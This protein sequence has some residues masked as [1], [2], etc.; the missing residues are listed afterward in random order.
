MIETIRELIEKGYKITR[1]DADIYTVMRRR[2]ENITSRRTRTNTQ[3]DE[4]DT[5]YCIMVELKNGDEI[6]KFEKIYDSQGMYGIDLRA[7]G[8]IYIGPRLVV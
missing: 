7:F 8:E 2:Y 1:F 3:D 5:R 4:D 6:V